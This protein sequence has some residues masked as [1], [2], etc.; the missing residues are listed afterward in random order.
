LYLVLANVIHVSIV[1]W[2]YA[3]DI[4]AVGHIGARCGT[5]FSAVCGDQA[6]TSVYIIETPAP[7]LIVGY[8]TTWLRRIDL[9]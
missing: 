4:T 2:P 8:S 6:T 1:Q 3:G 9:L 5:R 7:H